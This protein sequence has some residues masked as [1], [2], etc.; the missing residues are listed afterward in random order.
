MHP[1]AP[2]NWLDWATLSIIG[3]STLLSLLRGF[4]R[5]AL[6][7]ANWV[8]AFVLATAW[9]GQLA[10]LLENAIAHA[11]LRHV[12]AYGIIFI[13]SL[14]LGSMLG[15]LLRQLLGIA[16]LGGLD[17]LLGTAFGFARGLVVVVALL[18]LAEWALPE[19]NLARDSVLLPKL[20]LVVEWA[21][22]NFSELA[23]PGEQRA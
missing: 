7:L 12:A 19:A 11:A 8:L 18:Y 13:A 1:E 23:P 6:S 21:R 20:T 3:A 2:L 17:R 14:A 5:E 15:S 9:V 22:Q 4:A 16:G 10:A